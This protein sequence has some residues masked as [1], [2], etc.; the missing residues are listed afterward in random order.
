MADL[1]RLLT[2]D[3]SHAAAD[4]VQPPDF[5]PIERRGVQR[6]RTRT[7]LG[8]AAVV[9]VLL[10]VVGSL[11]VLG[12]EDASA[13]LRL[14]SHRGRCRPMGRSSRAPTS[15]RAARGRRWT[16]RSRPGGLESTEPQPVDANGE[17]ADSF[18]M[19]PF[20]VDKVYAR[21]VPRDR[22]A[23]TQVGTR[24]DDLVDVCSRSR[25]RSAARSTPPWRLS[26]GKVD[27]RVPDR[28][29]IEELLHGT[30]Y[31]LQSGSANRTRSYLVGVAPKTSSRLRRRRGRRTRGVSPT[32][33]TAPPAPS[34]EDQASCSRSSTPS[35]SRSLATRSKSSRHYPLARR[36]SIGRDSGRILPSAHRLSAFQPAPTGG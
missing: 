22:R 27:L 36:R 2:A 13:P 18:A 30:R 25:V 26:G 1:D 29:P 17:Q 15:F 3:I 12:A 28:L 7:L 34:G 32:P 21:R 8:A 5:T 6:R 4:A 35:T 14:T 10:G 31:R 24:V 16:S 9:V 11:R 20:V 33:S 19:Q 23:Q